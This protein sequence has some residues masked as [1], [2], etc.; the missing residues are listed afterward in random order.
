MKHAELVFYDPYLKITEEVDRMLGGY[1]PGIDGRPSMA[2]WL[3]NLKL[4]RPQASQAC[5]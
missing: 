2:S 3:P 1:Y 5:M 4:T